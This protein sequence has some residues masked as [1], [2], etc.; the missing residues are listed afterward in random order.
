VPHLSLDEADDTVTYE[1]RDHP[2]HGGNVVFVKRYIPPVPP[3][4]NRSRCPEIDEWDYND[5]WAQY[6]L[7][8]PG[9]LPRRVRVPAEADTR[10]GEFVGV[11]Q[12]AITGGAETIVV[13]LH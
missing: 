3:G 2:R 5:A 12:G 13:S 4:D 6:A 7:E 10:Y 1:P 8:A 11:L 9:S